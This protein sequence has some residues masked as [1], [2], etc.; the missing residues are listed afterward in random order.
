M[1]QRD[2]AGLAL[3]IE[4][5]EQA[6]A[7]TRCVIAGPILMPSGLRMPRMELDVRAVEL[8][9]AHADPREVRRQVVLA[10]AARDLARL[11]LLVRQRERLVARVDVD[12]AST[13]DSTPVIALTKSSDSRIDSTMRSYCAAL[14]RVPARTR[15]PSTRG[16][17]D[18]RSRRRSARG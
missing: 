14:R 10:R 17:A 11:R 1:D 12:A 9:R 18:R 13:S 4:D 3:R 16:D 2:A 7:A 15:R 5:V 8:R 6:D